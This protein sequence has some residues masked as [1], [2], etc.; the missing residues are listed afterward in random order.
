M[1]GAVLAD[2]DGVVGEDVDDGDLHDRG[3]ANGSAAIVAE[4]EESGP[5]GP[6]LGE[7]HPVHH[8]A[9][10]VLADAEVEV[11][12]AVLVRREVARPFEGEAGL[13]GRRQVGRSA[14]QPG[15]ALSQGVEDLL[16]GIATGEALGVGWEDRQI[17]VPTL[18]QL[19]ALHPLDLVGEARILRPVVRE[20]VHPGVALRG[21]ARAHVLREMAGDALRHQELGI[22]GPAIEAL[23]QLD[24]LG[25][26]GL[27]VGR[28]RVLLVG[29]AI[30]DVAVDDDE[31]RPALGPG[32]GLVRTIEHLEIVGIA[33]PA[34]VPAVGDE[35][36]GHVL[37]EGEVGMPLDRDL[38]VVVDPDEIVELEVAGEGGRFVGDALHHAAV[39]GEGVDAMREQLEARLVVARGQPLRCDGHAHAGRDA[40]TERP[41]GRLDARGPAVLRMAG[42]AAVE[43]PEAFDVV[44]GHGQLAERF[45][46]RVDGLDFGE[47]QE[48]IEQHRCVAHGQDEPVAVRPDGVVRIEAQVSLPERVRDRR[49][50]HGRARVAG[51]RL[52]HRVHRQRADCVDG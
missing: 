2:A 33:H 27:A 13:G 4:D 19:P 28:V 7:R 1:S 39:A 43:L 36:R 12:T 26:E 25:A 31:G 11:A 46:F 40:L 5:I 20:H 50:G 34:D 18:G 15:N 21:P 9:H 49:H 16:R 24:L 38:V 45:V 10:R 29:S 47:V 52:L 8:R 14:H 35:A 44:E 22:L 48:R 42:A 6:D 37:A 3:E 51:V 17:F 32:R 23:G 41:R 30:A